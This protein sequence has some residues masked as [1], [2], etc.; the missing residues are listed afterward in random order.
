MKSPRGVCVWEEGSE[1]LGLVSFGSP[2][3]GLQV[4]GCRNG[5]R[6]WEDYGMVLIKWRIM[7]SAQS[8]KVGKIKV[9]KQQKISV[10]QFN[11]IK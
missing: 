3:D 8:M 1:E 10:V 7:V 2:G 6:T 9:I 4:R 5:S 11:L